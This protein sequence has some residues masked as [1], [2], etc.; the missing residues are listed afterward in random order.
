MAAQS[1]KPACATALTLAALIL[2]ALLF[3]AQ[4]A[5]AQVGHP[6][7]VSAE[8]ADG[9]V[10]VNVTPLLAGAGI[11]GVAIGFGAQALVKDIISGVFFLIDDA[12]R[13]GEYIDIGAVK[14]TVENISIRSMQL[15][16]HNGPL[17][18]VPFGEIRHLKV[19]ARIRELFERENIKFA[20]REVTVRIAD[21]EA[22]KPLGEA[23]K[24]AAAA[25]T[26]SVVEQRESEA[27]APRDDR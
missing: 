17:N 19:F 24:E 15:R 6:I 11:V 13:R 25:A 1:T 4:P 16:H 26:R 12:F 21:H 23:E 8:D 5:M 18:T 2:A 3:A 7:A 27:A 20:H 14:G 9:Q 10:G 22:G